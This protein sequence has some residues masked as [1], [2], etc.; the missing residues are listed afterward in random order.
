MNYDRLLNLTVRLGSVLLENGAETYRVEESILRIFQGY[1]MPEC[2]VFVIPTML[3][4][5]IRPSEEETITQQKRV[6]SRG[7]DLTK[8]SDANNLCRKMCSGTMS[9]D[10]IEQAIDAIY[11]GPVY[12]RRTQ[13]LASAAA[14][15]SFCLFFSGSLLD[16]CFATLGGLMVKLILEKMGQWNTNT[17]FMH[18]AASATVTMMAAAEAMLPFGADMDKIIIGTIMLLVPGVT[19]T[20]CMRDTIAGDYISG[21]SKLMEALLIGTG[22]ALG[23]YIGMSVMSLLFS[24]PAFAAFHL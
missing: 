13:Y 14:A 12:S 22:V 19:L 24:L 1:H 8:I 21:L 7:T 17:F 6:R 18:V 9:L 4:I 2:D 3:I 15:F 10:E 11:A 20:T 16:A 23:T 5:T